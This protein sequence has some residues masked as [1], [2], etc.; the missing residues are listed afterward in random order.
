[1]GVMVIVFL[2]KNPDAEANENSRI[3]LDK[4][5]CQTRSVVGQRV[6]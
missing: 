3:V 1:M 5:W 6:V 4:M 2:I